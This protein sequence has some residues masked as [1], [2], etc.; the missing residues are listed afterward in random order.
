MAYSTADIN[1]IDRAISDNLRT[2]V[3]AED[4]YPLVYVAHY[5]INKNMTSESVEQIAHAAAEGSEDV[6]QL[7]LSVIAPLSKDNMFEGAVDTVRGLDNN[8]VEAYLRH[9]KIP[10]N[11]FDTEASTP[12]G[13]AKLALAI[14]DVE[15]GD[16]VVDY[17]CG[18][19]NF[20]EMAKAIRPTSNA[21]GVEA[22]ART[23]ALAKIR[24][25]ASES[26]I[27]Y[28][29]GDIFGFHEEHIAANPVDK[30]FSNY[31]WGI[32]TTHLQGT[33]RYIDDVLK[34]IGR[35]GRPSSADWV[36]NQL[37]V[38]S[39]TP[40][41]TA[42][43]IMSNGA[44][45]NGTDRSVREYFVKNGFIEAIVALPKGM[46]AP[47]TI[48]QTSLIVLR[49][50]GSKG[51]RFVDASDLGVNDRRGSSLDDEAIKAILGRLSEDSEKSAVKSIE[52]IAS[53]DFDL[54]AKRY[55]ER[56]IEVPNAVD[57]GS[58]CDIIRGAVVRASELDA[59]VCDEDTGMSYLNLGNI[60]DGSI[61]ENLPNLREL[62]P[63]LEKYC[64][65]DG[66]VLVSKN[67]APFKVVVADV[68][69]G[70]K[71]LANG[72]LYMVRVNREKI[73][74]YYLAAFLN[75]PTGKEL[76]AREAVGTTIPNV[77]VKALAAL[78]IP[79]EDEN[80]Q[81]SIASAYLAKTDEIKVLK[82]RL[83]RAQK[84]VADLF[85]EEA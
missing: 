40:E 25:K 71:I 47:Y 42:V 49:A 16:R 32:R 80:R 34:G 6:E 22:N 67:G 52:E 83:Q 60:A 37:L 21:I 81:K 77:P 17:G 12:D 44:C 35:Y 4:C 43:A 19:G 72:N 38:D 14:L 29:M 59:L 30:A 3:K 79:L 15:D 69:E 54:S 33:S 24:S 65:E 76:L 74:P 26:N 36:F 57:L 23:L 5:A 20:L 45:F 64:I 31:P 84:E 62:D 13:I 11:V 48:I 82:L 78:Q 46:F 61:D 73:N 9:G 55:L 27:E 41:G 68:P 53:R 18:K 58:V 39:L 56:E 85:D 7:L 51:I 66:D 2:F 50:G 8:D 28:H 70:R 63:K 75:S 1:N 10:R